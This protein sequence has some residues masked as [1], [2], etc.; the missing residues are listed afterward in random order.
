MD[1]RTE[2]NRFCIVLAGFGVISVELL[3]SDT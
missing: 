3:G 1:I 2:Q